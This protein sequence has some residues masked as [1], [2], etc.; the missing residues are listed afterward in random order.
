MY[1]ADFPNDPPPLIDPTLLVALILAM[2]VLM[3]VSF[4][5]GRQLGQRRRLGDAGD[6]PKTIHKAIARRAAM[7]AAA[8][9]NL[10]VAATARLVEEIHTRLG[11]AIALG[12]PSGKYL[13]AMMDALKAEAD[14]EEARRA[15]EKAA[16]DHAKDHHGAHASHDGEHDE[17]EDADLAVLETMSAP[18]IHIRTKGPII[19]AADRNRKK[20]RKD[21]HHKPPE[22]PKDPS[23]KDAIRTVR[24][25]VADFSDHWSRTETLRDLERLQKQM[26]DTPELAK[27]PLRDD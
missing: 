3:I 6:V 23:Y 27:E 18:S 24:Q 10:L 8:P 9:S 14:P 16:A 19:F 1:P 17:D 25:A 26:L 4:A 11:A 5:A 15:A 21:D 12:A 22:E 2:I 7:A 20:L 13:K